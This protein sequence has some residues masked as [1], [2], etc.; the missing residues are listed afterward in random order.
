[1]HRAFSDCL[2]VICLSFDVLQY[3]NIKE[4]RSLLK[5]EQDL[6]NIDLEIRDIKM[7]FQ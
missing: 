1:M 4:T 6:P 2:C 3:S 7:L 5:R